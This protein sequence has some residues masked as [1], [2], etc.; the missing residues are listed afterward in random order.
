[1]L[2]GRSSASSIE[3]INVV[4]DVQ[5]RPF[6]GHLDAKVT[7]VEFSHYRCSYCNAY[8]QHV[9]PEILKNYIDTGKVKYVF[10]QFP[11]Q[12]NQS[13]FNAARAAF[14]SNEQG[15]FT[16]MESYLYK[17]Q[18]D[19]T[20][21]ALTPLRKRDSAPKSNFLSV[22]SGTNWAC[23]SPRSCHDNKPQKC[24]SHPKIQRR[25]AGRSCRSDGKCGLQRLT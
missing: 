2:A 19:L 15:G 1:M 5:A 25:R 12:N 3:P 20:T 18:S 10:F 9:F 7:V 21:N 4:L 24:P 11:N 17:T 22:L 16:E 14:C 23:S 6:F 13:A 8:T